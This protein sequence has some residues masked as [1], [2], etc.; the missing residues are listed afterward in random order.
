MKQNGKPIR[1]TRQR[2]RT[3][4]Y[5]PTYHVWGNSPRDL[6]QFTY[7]T[8]RAMLLDSAVRKCL[9]IRRAPLYGLEF[10]Y[11]QGDKWIPGVEARKPE[12]AKFVMRQLKRIWDGELEGILSADVWGWSAGEITYRLSDYGLVE[13]D[14]LLPRHACDT[15]AMERDGELCGVRF[16]RVVGSEKGYV[17]LEFPHCW[18]HSYN[19]EAGRYYGQ[20]CFLGAYSPFADKWFNGGATDV[21]RLF[22]HKDAYGGVDIAYPEGMTPVAQPDGTI[23]EIPNRDIARQMAEQIQAGGVTTRPSQFG[24]DGAELWKITRAT[25]PAAPSHILQYPKDLDDEIAEGME[26]FGDLDGGGETGSWAGKRVTAAAFYGSEDRWALAVLRDLRIQV[27][28]PLVLYNF[29]KAEEFN[30][31]HKPLALQ[32]ME[33]QSN[34]GPGQQ[35]GQQGQPPGPQTQGQS[36]Q[37]SY[38]APQKMSLEASIGRGEESA[39][40]IVRMAREQAEKKTGYRWIT[41]GGSPGEK[42]EHEGGTRVAINADGEIVAGPKALEGRKVGELDQDVAGTK[43]DKRKDAKP[44]GEKKGSSPDGDPT[45]QPARPDSP[46]GR[47]ADVVS[48]MSDGAK[49]AMSAPLSNI[50]IDD[51]EN[52]DELASHTLEDDGQARAMRE[53]GFAMKDYPEHRQELEKAMEAFGAKRHGERGG[54]TEFDGTHQETE[55]DVRPGDAVE[56]VHPAWSYKSEDGFDTL[57]VPAVVKRASAPTD[58]RAAPGEKESPF[59]ADGKESP[60]KSDK[61]IASKS[62]NVRL[63]ESEDSTSSSQEKAMQTSSPHVQSLIERANKT[64]SNNPGDAGWKKVKDVLSSLSPGELEKIEAYIGEEG[65]STKKRGGRIADRIRSGERPIVPQSEEQIKAAEAAKRAEDAAE[66]QRKAEVAAANAAKRKSDIAAHPLE[67]KESGEVGWRTDKRGSRLYITGTRKGDPNVDRLRKLGAHWDADAGAWWVGASKAGDAQKIVEAV[68]AKK[69]AGA[70]EA[71]R[72]KSEGLGVAIPY[73][74]AKTREL[75]KKAGAIWDG[76]GKQWLMPDA[77][78]AEKIKTAV[79]NKS[80]RDQRHR[81]ESANRGRP[82]L[83]EGERV[84]SRSSESSQG[85]TAGQA[86]KDKDG[87]YWIVTSVHKPERFSDG[88]SSGRRVDDGYEHAANARPATSEET[89]KIERSSRI[90]QLEK[91]LRALSVGPDDER[92]RARHDAEVAAVMEE[93]RKLRGEA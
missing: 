23:L 66:R 56:V 42:G 11:Q 13:I 64:L 85:Y 25:V 6:P 41:I 93:L 92:L 46:M 40:R 71:K 14:R 84:F 72:R 81:E 9:A 43:K 24:A 39:E 67:S 69:S 7:H 83:A 1:A 18:W 35:P 38:Q 47:L 68:N 86:I 65:A 31:S 55:D 75:A 30:V 10:A 74:D 88:L 70:D 79:S 77:E 27:L 73:E 90:A 50:G 15:R 29:G 36:G 44:P 78:S 45:E 51:P 82:P 87:N 89:A 60:K 91:E 34:A 20:S 4:G 52:L 12:V 22:M 32:A 48:S 53:I 37:Q 59:N 61:P 28:E 5:Q 26:V 8:I 21:R 3:T 2:P 58:Q 63:E 33:Q 80:Q 16:D 76:I 49:R 62:E 54:V 19:P 17:D 57:A